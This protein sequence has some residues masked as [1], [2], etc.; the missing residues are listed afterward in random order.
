MHAKFQLYLMSL[1]NVSGWTDSDGVEW[2]I[3]L[4]GLSFCFSLAK[5]SFGK[6]GNV[7]QIRRINRIISIIV[8]FIVLFCICF[9]VSLYKL[10]LN[11]LYCCF[12]SL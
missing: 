3:V 5:A 2:I 8:S 10:Y 11:S 7:G 4:T 12:M 6:T 9:P 1:R